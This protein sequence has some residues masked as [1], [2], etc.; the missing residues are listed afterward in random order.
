MSR[1]VLDTSLF[2]A[3]EQGRPLGELPPGIDDAAV[4]IVTLAELELGVHMA[5]DA[6]TR[7]RRLATLTSARHVS[8]PLPI[9]ERV[10]SVFAGLVATLRE[11]RRSLRVQDAWIA[12]TAS[13][14]GAALLTQDKDFEALPGL[15]TVLLG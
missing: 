14:H 8:T 13:A 10:S 15:E 12:A 5:V 1:A 9:D 7:A 6:A 11:Q 2:V 4:S 3:E